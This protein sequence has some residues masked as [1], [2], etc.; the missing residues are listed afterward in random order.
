MRRMGHGWRSRQCRVRSGA[1]SEPVLPCSRALHGGVRHGQRS[2]R[3]DAVRDH[4]LLTPTAQAGA[5]C[6]CICKLAWSSTAHRAVQALTERTTDLCHT[7]NLATPVGSTCCSSAVQLS[8]TRVSHALGHTSGG[9]GLEGPAALLDVLFPGGRPLRLGAG[10]SGPGAGALPCL[11][12]CGC[13]GCGDK[14][15]RGW[16][17]SAERS[18]VEL[19]HPSRHGRAGD[20]SM[21]HFGTRLLSCCGAWLQPQQLHQD[22]MRTPVECFHTLW[23]DSQPHDQPQIARLPSGGL[24][25]SLMAARL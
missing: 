8:R 9:R 16:Q 3:V 5:S 10:P 15:F 11:C 18:A 4:V 6:Q 21:H 14:A 19:V 25:H 20:V 1:E 23:S 22:G 24:R 13:C 2:L 12:C 17:T 7:T